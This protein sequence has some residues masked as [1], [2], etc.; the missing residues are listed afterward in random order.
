LRPERFAGAIPAAST[1]P[2]NPARSAGHDDF[3]AFVFFG[4]AS[5]AATG[6]ARRGYELFER[7]GATFLTADA[8]NT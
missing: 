4:G 1:P 7:H 5:P 6:K 8:G 2:G 3:L